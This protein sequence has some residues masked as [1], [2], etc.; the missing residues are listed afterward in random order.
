MAKAKKEELVEPIEGQT[1]TV[2]KKSRS[3]K[4]KPKVKE[5]SVIPS[6]QKAEIVANV[7][8]AIDLDIT[9]ELIGLGDEVET[10][11]AP[12]GQMSPQAHQWMLFLERNQMTAEEWLKRY[13]TNK[14]KHHVEEILLFKAKK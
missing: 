9:V 6:D 11:P 5:E 12:K 10:A 14:F 3:G 8:K 1:E 4:R 2:V 13:P 7:A